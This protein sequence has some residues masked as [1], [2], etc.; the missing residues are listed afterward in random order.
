MDEGVVKY[1]CEWIKAPSLNP[2]LL[3][4]L[5]EWR[6]WC[7]ERRLI[8]QYPNGVG[9]G[10]ISMRSKNG[11][12]ISGT[13]T[14]G[15]ATLG[16]DG[17][18]EVIETAVEKNRLTCRGPIAS[19]S[20]GLTHA[21]IYQLSPEIGGIIHIH[22]QKMWTELLNTLPTTPHKIPYGTPEMAEAIK[23]LWK[24]TRLSKERIM[25]MGGHKEGIVA[26]G[27]TL[28]AAAEAINTWE[29]AVFG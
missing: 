20:E 28:Q 15:I 19:S 2:T 8:G 16:T 5:M 21:M 29:K 3:K 4:P 26:F 24:M 25:V 9:Y 7:F 6:E 27:N 14:G 11:F 18:C 10:N 22:H 13:Q 12:L 23:E 17:Y 1:H